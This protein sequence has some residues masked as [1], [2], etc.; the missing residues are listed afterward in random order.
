MA[1]NTR[2]RARQGWPAISARLGDPELGEVEAEELRRELRSCGALDAAVALAHE[3]VTLARHEL[4]AAD[5]PIALRSE[6]GEFAQRAAE[7]V[8]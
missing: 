6:L 1:L 2:P 8:R 3:H 4:D 5:L 7:R